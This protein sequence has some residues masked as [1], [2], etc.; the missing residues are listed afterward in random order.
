[1]FLKFSEFKLYSYHMS[2]KYLQFLESVGYY[3]TKNWFVSAYL[4]YLQWQTKPELL[5]KSKDKLCHD[6]FF[7]DFC[8]SLKL[9]NVKFR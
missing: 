2:K 1:M 3:L 8:I 7:L 6:E 5:T 9:Q 4:D